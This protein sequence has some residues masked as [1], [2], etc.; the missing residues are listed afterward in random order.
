MLAYYTVTWY[1]NLIGHLTTILFAKCNILHAIHSF[2]MCCPIFTSNQRQTSNNKTEKNINTVIAGA[3]LSNISHVFCICL[4][5]YHDLVHGQGA[6]LT[7]MIR[8]SY[9]AIFRCIAPGLFS[10]CTSEIKNV[11]IKQYKHMLSA[12][13][14][15]NQNSIVAYP[16]ILYNLM[17]R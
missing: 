11:I 10:D 15:Y 3:N 14:R 9:D 8:K 6:L 4:V 7:E 2:Y 1:D 12:V 13:S 16:I 17:V 5:Q